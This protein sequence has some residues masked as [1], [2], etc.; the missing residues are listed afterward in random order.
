MAACISDG[1]RK[2]LDRRHPEGGRVECAGYRIDQHVAPDAATQIGLEVVAS[3]GESILGPPAREGSAPFLAAGPAGLLLV[4]SGDPAYAATSPDGV[5]WTA[6]PEGAIPTGFDVASL[7]GTAS[8]YLLGGQRRTNATHGQAATLSSAD[9]RTWVGP[10]ALPL[11]SSL[12]SVGACSGLSTAV[13]S[14]S[15]GHDGLIALGQWLGSPAADIWWQSTD[16]Q[17]WQVLGGYPPVGPANATAEACQSQ[18]N[19]GLVGDG[20]RMLAFR[21]G[22]AGSAWTSTDGLR[23]HSLTLTGDLP[24]AQAGPAILLPGGVLL[25]DGTTKWFGAAVAK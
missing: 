12:G 4:S 21:A 10:P 3:D 7:S 23:W 14:I 24:R 15:V 1:Q 19:G 18:A 22:R 6:M 20:Q 2:R 9:G 11:A 8:G 25:G 16:G 13:E 5:R 17:Q